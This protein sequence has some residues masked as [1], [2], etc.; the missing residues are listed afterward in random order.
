MHR[1][2]IADEGDAEGAVAE[3]QREPRRVGA[4]SGLS[5]AYHALGRKAESDAALAELIK[6][7]ETTMPYN[8]AYVLRASGRS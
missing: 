7:Y 2:D 5:M 1:R 4:S 6:K 3:M 8:I